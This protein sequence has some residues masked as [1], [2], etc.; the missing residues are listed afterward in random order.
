MCGDI[1]QA[2]RAQDLIEAPKSVLLM[3]VTCLCFPEWDISVLGKPFKIYFKDYTSFVSLDK[4][5]DLVSKC[6][7]HIVKLH[8]LNLID[9]FLS[10]KVAGI[11]I[12]I[13]VWSLLW[14]DNKSDLIWFDLLCAEQTPGLSFPFGKTSTPPSI[15]KWNI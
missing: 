4:K 15:N 8:I 13:P 12:E 14:C 7:I 9:H 1:S 10:N 3:C 5:T 11:S 2:L 6:C